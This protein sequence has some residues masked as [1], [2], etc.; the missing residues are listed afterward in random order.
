MLSSFVIISLGKKE[1]VS[2][3]LLCYNCH[4]AFHHSFTLPHGAMGWSV[5]CDCGIVCMFYKKYAM[6]LV[7]LFKILEF[8]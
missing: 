4:F 2:L 6:F 7:Q 3:F 1:L 8:V 5:V